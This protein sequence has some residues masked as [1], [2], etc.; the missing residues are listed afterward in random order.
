MS[1]LLLTVESTGRAVRVEQECTLGRA[2]GNTLDFPDD[3]TMSREHAR[4]HRR[5]DEHLLSDLGT[6]NG[7]FLERGGAR[8]R[9][10]ETVLQPGDVVVV[11]AQRLLVSSAPAESGTETAIEDPH[12]TQVPDATRVGGILPDIGGL[13]APAE[14]PASE[15][16]RKRRWWRRLL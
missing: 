6:R 1:G 10:T 4:I 12:L 11:G 16:V 7:S 3:D 2:A 14:Q 13:D 9:V 15:R 5:G 8:S